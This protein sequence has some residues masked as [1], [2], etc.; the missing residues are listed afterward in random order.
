MKIDKFDINGSKVAIYKVG[1]VRMVSISIT[2]KA[3][4]YYENK[5]ESGYFHLLEHLVLNG[6]KRF[7]SFKEISEYKEKYG[8]SNNAG[9]SGEWMEFWF[10]FPDIYLEESLELI[11]EV[12]FNST[13]SFD[14]IENELSIVEQEYYDSWSSPY[15]KFSS[16]I[17]SRL[18]GK[19]CN[20]NNEVLGKPDTFR[21]APQKE[22]IALY[23][24]FFRPERMF[25]G[26]SGNVKSD[27]VKNILKKI[28]PKSRHKFSEIKVKKFEPKLGKLLFK[29]K[30]EQPYIR[31]I[32]QIPSYYGLKMPMRFG[33]GMFNYLLGNS[34]NS[35][36]FTKIRQEMGLVYR[37]N[38]TFWDW[39]EVS[40]LEIYASTDPS[41]VDKVISESQKILENLICKPIE[42]ERFDRA[43]NYL[44]LKTLMSFSSPSKIA[45][46]LSFSL[47]YDRAVY[48]PKK[49]NEMAHKIKFNKVQNWFKKN[50]SINKQLVAIMVSNESGHGHN[51]SKE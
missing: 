46:N 29:N 22:L 1:A 30:V 50:I 17:S 10:D 40:Y 38:S 41:K 12:M 28:I 36:L 4:A 34:S 51:D 23:K 3:G 15:K 26:I 18:A 39:P 42:K 13:V 5:N 35:D 9:T 47:F 49:I 6:T 14:N 45:N 20:L 48:T 43:M 19:T 25:W 31:I 24:K 2:I 11:K 27:K 32:W 16:E 7:K 37:I 21:E 33:L 44:D 8:I